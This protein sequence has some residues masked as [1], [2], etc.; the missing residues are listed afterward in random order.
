MDSPRRSKDNSPR[1]LSSM[2]GNIHDVFSYVP[3]Q[4]SDEFGED[5]GKPEV[6]ALLD[7]NFILTLVMK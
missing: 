1:S 2:A 4:T 3:T 6:T 5:E 7:D